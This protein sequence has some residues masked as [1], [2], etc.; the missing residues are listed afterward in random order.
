V[1]AAHIETPSPRNPLG[2]K[3]C[4][5]SG[6]IPATG[7]LISAIEDALSPFNVRIRDLPLSPER[8]RRIVAEGVSQT[9]KG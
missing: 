9:A 6:T 5:E 2:M 4:G 3:G 8:L 1:A 7:T